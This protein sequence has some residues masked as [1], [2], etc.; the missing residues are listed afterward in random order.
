MVDKR[1][2][3]AAKGWESSQKVVTLVQAGDEPGVL[4]HPL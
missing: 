2:G 4:L 1:S 3:Y